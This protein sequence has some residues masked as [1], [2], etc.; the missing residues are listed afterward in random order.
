MGAYVRHR[1]PGWE[2]RLLSVVAEA[3]LRP[4]AWGL[5]DCCLFALRCAE[6][7]TG[8]SGLVTLKLYKSSRGALREVRRLGGL[9]QAASDALGVPLSNAL[10]A[11]RG[12]IVLVEQVG[13]F[14]NLALGV[15]LGADALLTGPQGL[16]SIPMTDPRMRGA[17]YI[18][19]R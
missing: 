9:Q 18:G 19:H 15:C 5:N 10:R 13:P 4:F 11:Q 2:T 1:V 12:D 6:A 8:L 16:V 7:V 3:A 17:F 14:D